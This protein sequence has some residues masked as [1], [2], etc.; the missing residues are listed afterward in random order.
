MTSDCGGLYVSVDV[1]N[2]IMMGVVLRFELFV[3]IMIFKV[4]TLVALA[5]YHKNEAII[6]RKGSE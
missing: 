1:V 4:A 6:M 2:G 3:D 5:D